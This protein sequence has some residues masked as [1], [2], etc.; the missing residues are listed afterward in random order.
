MLL[1]LALAAAFSFNGAAHSAGP[2]VVVVP[3]GSYPRQT[4]T[5]GNRPIVLDGRGKVDIADVEINGSKNVEL[6]NMRIHGWTVDSG[7]GITFRRIN[8]RGT[9]S[10]HA[11]ASNVKVIGGSVGPSR[12]VGSQIAV[13]SN[14]VATPSRGILIDGVTFHDASRD[15][16][17]HTECL[18]IA[19]GDGIVI[20][21][22]HFIRCAVMDVFVTWWYFWPKV[23]PPTHL[24]ILN[25]VFEKT[26]DGYYSLKFANYPDQAG[27][28]WTDVTIKGNTFRQAPNYEG[29]RVR[30]VA[31]P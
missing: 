24:S 18:M 20:R 15:P 3:P 16:G 31:Q 4:L 2:K 23:G 29:R 26:T 12:N 9:F 7:S 10:I 13:P 5:A 25:N 30:F 11:P 27:L 19:Q 8:T 22:S 6:R 1:T 17:Q 14:N 21:N 28:A